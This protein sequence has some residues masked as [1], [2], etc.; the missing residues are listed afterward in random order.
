MLTIIAWPTVAPD[1]LESVKNAMLE[2]VEETLKEAGCI[3]YE[4]HQ[5]LKQP[6]RLTF[7]ETWENRELWMQ[8][9]QGDAIKNFNKKIAGGIIDFELQEMKKIS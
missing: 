9:M 2:L 3:R 7:V 1:R 8:H 4:L 6:N 5:D